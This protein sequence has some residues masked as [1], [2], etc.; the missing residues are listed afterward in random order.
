MGPIVIIKTGT[1]SIPG[2]IVKGSFSYFSG[3]TLN[4]GP[5]SVTGLYS[6]IDAPSNGY[7]VYQIDEINLFT[8][9]V[10]RNSTELNTILNGAGA[11]GTTLNDKITWATNTNSIFINSGNT[12]AS[13]IKIFVGGNF[14]T[15]SGSSQNRL[16]R[17]NSDGSKDTSFNIGTGFDLYASPIGIQSD[18]KILVGGGFTE[19][20]GSTQNKLIRLN[21]DGSKDTSF[22]IGS[23]FNSDLT[24]VSIQSDGKILAGGYFTDFTGTTQNYL[25]RLNSDGSKDTSFNI[26]TG[27][28]N[29]VSSI[30]IQSDG[31]ILVGGG[32]T[33]F[34][35][36][37]Q[38]YL[39]RLNSDGSKDTSFNIGTGFDSNVQSISIQWDGKILAGGFF[40]TFTGSSQNY[41]IRLNSDGSKDTSFNIGTGVGGFATSIAIQSD[42]KILVG[43]GFITFAGVTQNKLIRLNSDGSKDTSFNIGSGFGTVGGGV[44][45]TAIQSDGKILAVGGFTEFSGSTQNF[46]IRLNSNGSKDT[47]FNIGSGFNSPLNSIS[48]Q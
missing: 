16:I 35:G 47:S 22:N 46:I 2:A 25:I 30:A 32:F 11:T 5:T 3:S 21:S 4:L 1:T 12:I 6:G 18:G 15:Y 33:T 42:G 24:S 27:F 45:S 43:G 38:N 9:R 7:T 37:S 23:G 8:I 28:D 44:V 26:G 29:T 14:T 39:I 19:F 34:N 20:T 41:L 31:K 40:T 10:A 17:L 48:I 13:D 36:G